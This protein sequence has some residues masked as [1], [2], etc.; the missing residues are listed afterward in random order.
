MPLAEPF[1]QPKSFRDFLARLSEFPRHVW[2]YIPVSVTNI[3]L[4]T[5]C[6]AT[7]F[8]SRDLCPDARDEFDALVGRTGMRCFFGRDQLEDIL[9]N[10]KLQRVDF[11]PEH[12]IAAIDLYWKHDDLIDLSTRVA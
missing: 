4:D 3:T 7:A 2:L 10:L 5:L 8:N 1:E 9:A 11:T 12:F 6:Y